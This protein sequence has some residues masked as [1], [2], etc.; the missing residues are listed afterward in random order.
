MSY[1]VFARYYDRLM[2]AVDYQERAGYLCA[3]LK[4][5]VYKRQLLGRRKNIGDGL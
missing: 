1:T 3:V 4:K 2:H 5:D